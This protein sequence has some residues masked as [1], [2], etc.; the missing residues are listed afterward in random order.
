MP[1]CMYFEAHPSG[2]LNDLFAQK[3]YQGVAPANANFLFV[4][5]DANYAPDVE[6][7]AGFARIV[8]YHTDGAAFWHKYRVHHP[9]LLPDYAG[10]GRKY[11]R[12]FARIGFTPEHADQVSFVE[13]LHVP[14]V[15]RNK[16]AREDFLGSHLQM[17]NDVILRGRA[18]HVFISPGV[19]RLM[20]ATR[21]FPWLPPVPSTRLGAL[22]VWCEMKG[23]RV[24]AP[25]HFSVYGKFEQQKAAEALAIH[26]LVATQ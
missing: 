10:D 3:P 2:Q 23:K 13:L 6:S 16:L 7:R 15:G 11:H 26:A 5:L 24:Y 9:F 8:E 12:S 14:T 4:G 20:R 25:L 18:A 19:A 17:L 22:N 21:R 1:Q